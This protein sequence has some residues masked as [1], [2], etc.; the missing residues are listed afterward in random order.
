ML[1][2]RI[3][4]RNALAKLVHDTKAILR[5]HIALLRCLAKPG[6]RLRHVPAEAVAAEEAGAHKV[7]SF[8]EPLVRSFL[9]VFHAS[10]YIHLDSCHLY[11]SQ[12]LQTTSRILPSLYHD[13]AGGLELSSVQVCLGCFLEQLNSSLKVLWKFRVP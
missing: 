8:S 2:L 7:L 11:L 4:L 6:R 3:T 1:S 13:E 12:Q 10:W 5:H 9:D